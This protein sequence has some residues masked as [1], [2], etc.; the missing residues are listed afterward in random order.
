MNRQ[1]PIVRG[2]SKTFFADIRFIEGY[3]TAG[4]DV[5]QER[6]DEARQFP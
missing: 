6:H 4:N 5:I 3:M 2:L 1:I